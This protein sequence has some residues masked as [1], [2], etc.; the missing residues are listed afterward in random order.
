[1]P[2]TPPIRPGVFTGDVPVSAR[3]IRGVATSVTAFVGRALQGPVDEPTAVASFTGFENRFGGLHADCPLAYA[4]RDF[5]ANGGGRALIVRLA[6]T[7]RAA[8]G[9]GRRAV[10]AAPG[11]APLTVDDYIGHEAEERGLYALEKADLFN[12]LCIPPD[13]R[14]GNLP[15]TVIRRAAEYCCRRRAM[16]IVDPDREWGEGEGAAGRARDGVRNLGLTGAGM[17]NATLFFPRI[18]QP[19]PERQGRLET[20]APCGAVA[21]VIARTDARRGVWKAP[22]GTGAVLPGVAGLQAD[23][24]EADSGTLRPAGINPLRLLPGV[25]I[26]IWGARTLSGGDRPTDEFAHVP[27]RRLAL[28]IEESLLRGLAWT[29]FEPD[30]EPL[31]AAVRTA[32][33]AFMDGLRRQGAFAGSRPEDAWFVKCDR[34]TTTP[35]ESERGIVTLLAGFAPARPRAFVVL[36]IPVRV[37]GVGRASPYEALPELDAGGNPAGIATLTLEHGGWERDEIG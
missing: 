33:G 4:V 14:D 9:I 20:F 27:V 34:E 32:A 15:P 24:S 35:A 3:P 37:A 16:L 36:R 7:G 11:G 25:G 29:A 8:P 23:L 13:T 31:R 22:A 18:R 12:L 26:C 21:G 17:R 6:G 19:D 5:F 30:G 1:M 10:R 28:F 2:T